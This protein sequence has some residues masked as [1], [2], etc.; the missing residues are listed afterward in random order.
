M[1]KFFITATDTD[2]GKTFVTCSILK[3]FLDSGFNAKAVKPVQ[4]GCEILGG[5]ILAPDVSEYKK[6]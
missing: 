6:S 4:T 1:K 5:K 2:A 3:A